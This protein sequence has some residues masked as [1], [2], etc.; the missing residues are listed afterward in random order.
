MALLTIRFEAFKNLSSRIMN[1][2]TDFLTGH[3]D[4]TAGGKEPVGV[5]YEH[6]ASAIRFRGIESVQT[7][8][9]N[10]DYVVPV[11]DTFAATELI[12]PGLTTHELVGN[13]ITLALISA[14]D[15]TRPNFGSRIG[16]KD[17]VYL[18]TDTV[19][20][21]NYVEFM[22]ESKFGTIIQDGSTFTESGGY[23]NA[24][25][26]VFSDLTFRG[27]SGE[28]ITI[29]E[30]GNVEFEN[31]IFECYESPAISLKPESTVLFRD[32]DFLWKSDTSGNSL[33]EADLISGDITPLIYA[34]FAGCRFLAESSDV[35][36]FRY[37]GFDTINAPIAGRW[38]DPMMN[39]SKIRFHNCEFYQ[40]YESSKALI[41]IWKHDSRPDT[42]ILRGIVEVGFC[43]FFVN[44][45]NSISVDTTILNMYNNNYQQIS[46]L[47]HET[48]G[49]G[50]LYLNG[51]THDILLRSGYEYISDGSDVDYTF[52]DPST[53]TA[54]GAVSYGNIYSDSLPLQPYSIRKVPAYRF[55]IAGGTPTDDLFPLY[56]DPQYPAV[57]T[58]SYEELSGGFRFTDGEF[59]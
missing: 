38:A 57:S 28:I 54:E 50:N 24:Y 7:A 55:Y 19:T 56:Y 23:I 27:S 10:R 35:C 43:N 11:I 44:R 59:I 21:D 37:R 32:C 12:G 58:I 2:L 3:S 14:I 13:D 46:G 16:I 40:P 41:E 6:W 33:I 1:K 31:C 39:M 47:Y 49:R 17:N 45:T 5:F 15:K 29:M 4:S 30:Y 53:I 25:D 48:D 51:L 34:T 52:D 22:G 26:G 42:D 18:L 8:I 20:T 9:D 36:F